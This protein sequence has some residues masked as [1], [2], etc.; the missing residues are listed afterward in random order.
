[1]NWDDFFIGI[2][3]QVA[4]KSKDPSTK[5]G[6]VIVEDNRII[7]T[8]YNGFP[9]GVEDHEKRYNHRETKYRYIEHC[10]RNAIY[11]AAKAGISLDG[12]IMYLTGPPCHE[13]TR[14]IIQAGIKQVVWPEDN[15]F[16]N[17]PERKKRWAFSS[18]T[19]QTMA[20]E[21]G[22]EFRRI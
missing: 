20:D 10:D 19:A 12:S 7:S 17:D 22:V 11:S 18:A 16:E 13:C 21:A 14:G 9:R 1:M 2:C 15:P 5:T 8:G 3:K 6:C 4:L